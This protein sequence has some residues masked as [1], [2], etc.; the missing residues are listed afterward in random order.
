MLD[1]IYTHCPGPCPILTGT[2]VALQRSLPEDLRPRTWFVSITLDP[3]RDTSEALRAYA[4]ARGANLASWSFVTGPT[5]AVDTVVRAFGV[6]KI[7]AAGGEID[8]VVATFLID[9]EGHIAER[10]VG[11]DHDADEILRDLRRIL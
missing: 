2:H 10:Y 11:L 1:F 6:G 4:A 9:P 5:A 8:H 7:P 3:E